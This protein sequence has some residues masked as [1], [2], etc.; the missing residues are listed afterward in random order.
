MIVKNITSSNLTVSDM[1]SPDNA[2]VRLILSPNVEV[3]LFNEDVEKSNI[4]LSYIGDNLVEVVDRETEP[5]TGTS[6]GE[7]TK[8]MVNWALC[9]DVLVQFIKDDGTLATNDPEIY[10][11]TPNVDKAIRL[12]VTDGDGTKDLLNSVS[13]VLVSASGETTVNGQASSATVTFTNGLAT[14]NIN[15]SGGAISLTLSSFTHPLSSA[16]PPCIVSTSKTATVNVGE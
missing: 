5:T 8:E 3:T 15:S 13:T 10:S 9:N 1:V 4:L 14:V 12:V 11:G 16:V 7:Q 6:V 2:A